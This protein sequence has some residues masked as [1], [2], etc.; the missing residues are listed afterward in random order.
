MAQL[1]HLFSILLV[2][3][4]C[5]ALANV[6]LKAKK[7]ASKNGQKRLDIHGRYYKYC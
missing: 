2:L 5:S 6:E 7:D 1:R 3:F 4:T